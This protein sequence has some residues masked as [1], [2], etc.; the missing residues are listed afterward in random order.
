METPERGWSDF[1]RQ[2]PGFLDTPEIVKPKGARE[3]PLREKARAVKLSYRDQQRRLEE[4]DVLMPHLHTEIA[5]HE[6]ALED[7]GFYARDP[8]AF[9]RTMVELDTARRTLASAE[10]EWLDL[11]S[12]REALAAEA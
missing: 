3:R 6:R 1:T 8:K 5:A 12:K 10:E 11:E 7:A 4:L 9:D 2:N